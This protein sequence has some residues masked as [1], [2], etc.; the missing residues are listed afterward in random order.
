MKR[1]LLLFIF[2][3]TTCTQFIPPESKAEIQLI[4]PYNTEYIQCIAELPD[5]SIVTYSEGKILSRVI[6]NTVEEQL[7]N[8]KYTLIK[9]NDTISVRNIPNIPIKPGE[10]TNIEGNFLTTEVTFNIIISP[11]FEGDY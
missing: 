2:L 11:E 5:T 8:I 3:F 9:D 4:D 10:C 1:L 6:L 7:V